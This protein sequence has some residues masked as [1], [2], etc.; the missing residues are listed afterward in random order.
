MV[1]PPKLVFVCLLPVYFPFTSLLLDYLHGRSVGPFFLLKPHLINRLYSSFA[2]AGGK[3]L[4]CRIHL[5]LATSTIVGRQRLRLMSVAS[6]FDYCQGTAGF[7][8][9]RLVYCTPPYATLI[10]AIR[11]SELHGESGSSLRFFS[12]LSWLCE[13]HCRVAFVCRFY[14]FFALLGKLPRLLFYSAHTYSSNSQNTSS[15]AMMLSPLSS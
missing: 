4:F 7:D 5:P 1:T 10:L 9:R 3:Y 12:V 8:Y 2:L 14:V 6:T 11:C 13:T 15:I